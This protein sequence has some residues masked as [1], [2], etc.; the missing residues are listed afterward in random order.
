MGYVSSL[1]SQFDEIVQR[2][3]VCEISTLREQVFEV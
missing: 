2:D 1:Q 3:F